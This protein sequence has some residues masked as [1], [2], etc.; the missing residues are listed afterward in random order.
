MSPRLAVLAGGIILFG[1]LPLAAQDPVLSQMYGSGVHAYF[2]HDYR[3][4]Y[5]YLSAAIDGGTADPRCYYYRGLALL[6][7]GRP[8]DAALD[9]EQGALLE[10]EDVNNFYN[11]ARSIQRIQG[12]TR[13]MLEQYRTKARLE[14]MKREDQRRQERYGEIQAAEERVLENR[15]AAAEEAPEDLPQPPT[16][17]DLMG[18]GVTPTTSVGPDDVP[19]AEEPAEAPAE[20]PKM[21][22]PA[23]TEAPAKPDVVPPAVDVKPLAK[24]AAGMD[25][26]DPFA[27]PAPAEPAAEAPAEPAA[28]MPAEPEEEAVQDDPFA[29][30][31]PAEPAAEAPAEPAAE[32]PAEPAEEPAQDDPFAAP[33]PAEPAAEAP[34]EPAAEMPA[35]PEEEAAQD[36]PFAAP[37]ATMPEEPAEEAADASPFQEEKLEE[38]KPE[39]EAEEPA[40]E[41]A[42]SDD[43]F[44]PDPKE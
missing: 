11:V 27:A 10:A 30:P 16:V 18:G 1:T 15:A 34:A 44:A 5:D 29:A 37:A 13:L 19:E 2:G 31:A 17:E 20:A 26:D 9:F 41:S 4:S 25:E 24:P 8:E 42:P 3:Q 6:Q 12:N 22:A 14:A 35:E 43:P 28:E 36:D 7:L 33:A 38:A 21:E 32:M 23:P 39:E 40:D